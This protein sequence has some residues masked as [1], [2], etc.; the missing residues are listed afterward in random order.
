[1][2]KKTTQPTSATAPSLLILLAALAV[3]AWFVFP[4]L[5]VIGLAALMAFLFRPLYKKLLSSTKRSGIAAALT[6]FISTVLVLIPLGLVLLLTV[7]QLTSLAGSASAYA[8][9]NNIDLPNF[10]ESSI[11]TLNTAIA[12]LI[13]NQEIITNQGIADFLRSVIPGAAQTITT[14]LVGVVGNIPT[15]VILTIMYTALFVELLVYGE[16]VIST[17]KHLSPF[18]QEVTT[19]YLQRIADMTNAMAKGQL[20]ISVIISILS[21]TLLL[22]LGLHDYYF[23]MIVLFTVLNLVPLGCGIVVI[24]AALLAIMLGNIVPGIVVLVLYLVVSNLDSLIR[25]KIMP[26]NARL[27]A[28]LTM[29]A[30]FGGITYFGLLG[31]IYGPII[32]IV[33]LTTVELYVNGETEFVATTK[34][35]R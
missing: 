2:V 6:F 12:P 20:L 11:S 32:V 23:L 3:G 26:K 29:L 9:N 4:Y 16:K 33:V 14:V 7:T 13:G 27:S 31:I 24:P 22:L 8:A 34:S 5:S 15:M 25:P 30:A 28:G 35:L 10:I 17:I 1:M 21:A 19:L 18:S